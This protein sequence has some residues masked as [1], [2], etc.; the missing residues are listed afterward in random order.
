MKN[1]EH[2]VINLKTDKVFLNSIPYNDELNYHDKMIK[3]YTW[4]INQDER[5]FP[6]IPSRPRRNP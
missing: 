4:E 3:F 2:K 1:E 6:T 5:E